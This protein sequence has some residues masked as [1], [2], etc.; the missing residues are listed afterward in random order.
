MIVCMSRRICMDLCDAIT[1]LRL[2]WH[3]EG[4]AEGFVKVSS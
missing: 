4:D 3:D 2:K 1:A